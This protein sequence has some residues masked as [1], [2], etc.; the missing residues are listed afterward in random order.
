MRIGQREEETAGGHLAEDVTQAQEWGSDAGW[1]TGGS[2]EQQ[3]E[4]TLKD[5]A[6]PVIWS[7]E[8]QRKS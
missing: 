6:K 5:E 3:Q 1:G 8:S 4:M 7:L 2:C